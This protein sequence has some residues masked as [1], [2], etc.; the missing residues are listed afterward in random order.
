MFALA[1]MI[2]V[3]M[4]VGCGKA[5]QAQI[6]TVNS[7]IDSAMVLEA[8]V[9]VPAEIAAV[10][11]SMKAIMVEV[12]VQN[13]KLFKKFGAVEEKL[14][15]TLE[16]A[17]KAQM[18]TVSRKDEVKKQV[19]T[20]MTDIKAVIEE[21]TKLFPRAPRGKEGT[22]VL[23][24]MKTEM[25]TIEESVAQ[26]QAMYDKGAYMDAFNKVSAAKETADKI[27]TELKDAIRK[28]GGRI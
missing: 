19:E 17:R 28:V 24:Q 16:A 20:L 10:Q 8:A 27:N 22:E 25:A 3:A 1:T 14:A 11:D 7:A 26:A 15:V 6:D 18:S 21:N 13:S 2:M 9:Y 23:A 4:M 5:P 12:E